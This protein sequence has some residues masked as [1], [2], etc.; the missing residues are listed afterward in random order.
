M[1]VVG[2]IAMFVTAILVGTPSPWWAAILAGCVLVVLAGPIS[3]NGHVYRHGPVYIEELG[4]I[5]AHRWFPHLRRLAGIPILSC[6]CLYWDSIGR[7]G[8]S[9][10]EKER[11]RIW[12]RS[13]LGMKYEYQ[14]GYELLVRCV[15]CGNHYHTYE[16]TYSWADD[17]EIVERWKDTERLDPEYD[18]RPVVDAAAA[19][20]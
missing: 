10:E 1:G 4:W 7:N 8:P 9:A 20:S 2:L 12:I 18:D 16:T 13:D 6:G 11:T 14:T 5:G 15:N 19:E 3:L 17:A